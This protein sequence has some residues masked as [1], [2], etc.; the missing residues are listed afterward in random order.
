M[1]LARIT[2]LAAAFLVPLPAAAQEG[3]AR[4]RDWRDVY[5]QPGQPRAEVDACLPDRAWDARRLKIP[6]RSAT[7]GIVAQC[8]VSVIFFEGPQGSDARYQAQR[9]ID[10]QDRDIVQEAA[11][12]VTHYRACLGD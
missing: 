1:R 2:L 3:C 9:E 11:A 4:P 12:L 8:E 10:A 6:L 7:G 5:P